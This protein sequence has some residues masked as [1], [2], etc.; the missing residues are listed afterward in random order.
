MKA[1]GHPATDF[2]GHLFEENRYSPVCQYTMKHVYTD[3]S[4][5][6]Q[7]MVL[8]HRWSLHP[9]SKKNKECAGDL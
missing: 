7:N 5:D 3:H 8:I 2:F 4:R 9:G 1:V 6:H